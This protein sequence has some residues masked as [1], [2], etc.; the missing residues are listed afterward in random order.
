MKMTPKTVN[1]LLIMLILTWVGVGC[2]FGFWGAKTGS[3][4]GQV[5]DPKN[6]PIAEAEIQTSPATQT[7]LTDKNG[8]FS[9][10]DVKE[11]DYTVTFLKVGYQTKTADA[12]VESGLS[13]SCWGSSSNTYIEI[14]LVLN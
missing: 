9:I 7:V 10:N 2:N 3:I 4:S 14:H 8:F 11:G 12:R 13:F 6:R 5:L 1:L